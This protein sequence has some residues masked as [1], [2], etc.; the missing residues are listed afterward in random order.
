MPAEQKSSYSKEFNI[1]PEF[2][3]ILR[4]L[5]REVLRQQPKD[6]NKF[7]VSLFICFPPPNAFPEYH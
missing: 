6:I 2:P 5:T 7:A 4:G 3:D 1:P